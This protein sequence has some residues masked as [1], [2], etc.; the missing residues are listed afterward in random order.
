[1]GNKCSLFFP[2]PEHVNEHLPL[3]VAHLRGVDRSPEGDVDHT[4]VV[5]GA[6]DEGG[7]V[8]GEGRGG[9]EKKHYLVSPIFPNYVH[10]KKEKHH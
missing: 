6:V 10:A 5:G 2:V 4:D 1:M 9:P 8:L 7:E 3:L